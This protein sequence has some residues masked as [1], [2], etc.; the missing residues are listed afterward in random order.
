M[1]AEGYARFKKSF[2]QLSCTDK[3]AQIG[4]LELG[5]T[6]LKIVYKLFPDSWLQFIRIKSL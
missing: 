2:S 3:N 4:T 5:K 6:D 1:C